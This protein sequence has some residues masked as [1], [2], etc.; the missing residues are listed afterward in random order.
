MTVY[1]AQGR[2]LPVQLLSRND[3]SM[4]VQLLNVTNETV[5]YVAVRS[6]KTSPTGNNPY[7]IGIDF[8]NAPVVVN[9]FVSGTLTQ[10]SPQA[11][12][13][14][15]VTRSQLF[16]LQLSVSDKKDTVPTAARVTLFDSN[17]QVVYTAVAMN[18]RTIM[19]DILLAPGNYTVVIAG[20]TQD[21][22]PL[23]GLTINLQLE[24]MADPIGP[25]LAQPYSTDSTST[26]S[27]T[28]TT[29]P[30]TSPSSSGTTSDGYSITTTPTLGGFLAPTNPYSSPWW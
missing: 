22:S 26:S 5:Y 23:L 30:T 6:A 28:T 9:S 2:Q 10:N 7:Q 15:Q 16:H 3:N 21:G 8:R 19:Q 18:N 4:T 27:G 1:D 25:A 14:I 20:A 29:S 24:A 13:T 17:N 12:G 11:M